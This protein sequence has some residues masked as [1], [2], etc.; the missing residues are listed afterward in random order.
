VNVSCEPLV[1]LMAGLPG[2]GKTTLARRM[3]PEIGAVILNRDEI[4]DAIFPESFLDYSSEQNQVGT[5]AML[6]VLAYLLRRPRPR[7]VILDGK[8]FSRR[9]EIVQV[10]GLVERG[11]ARLLI[12]HCVAPV[13]VIDGR[14][15][16]GLADPRNARAERHPEKAAR[17]R[18]TFEPIELTHVTIDTSGTVE[19]ILM[20]A[21]AQVR[22]FDRRGAG[23]PQCGSP[24]E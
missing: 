4:R 3:A 6:G 5:E 24:V 7:F 22:A 14:L 17:I 16:A 15:Q 20:E 9:D 8:P 21:L 2:V 10:S 18:G 23:D 11:A 12:F 19:R 13:E 1:I